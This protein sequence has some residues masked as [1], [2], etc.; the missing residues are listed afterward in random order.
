[1]PLEQFS[2][3]LRSRFSF[4]GFIVHPNRPIPAELNGLAIFLQNPQQQFSRHHN[5]GIFFL[6]YHAERYY[7]PSPKLLKS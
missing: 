1:M 2:P 3:L 5:K 7:R 4:R 6:T